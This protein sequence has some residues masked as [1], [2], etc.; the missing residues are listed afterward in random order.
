MQK[1]KCRTL[2]TGPPVRVKCRTL[3]K[4][5]G[6]VSGVAQGVGFRGVGFMVVGIENIWI[7]VYI[8]IYIYTMKL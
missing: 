6:K 4:A 8:F 3:D 2:D 5:S 1:P 7:Y